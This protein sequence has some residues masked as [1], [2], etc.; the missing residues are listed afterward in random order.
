MS[1]AFE[2]V[3]NGKTVQVTGCSPN[4]TLLDFLRQKGFTGSKEGCAE[5]DCGACSVAILDRA[6]DGKAAYR[7][8][9]SCLVPACLLAGREVISVEGVASDTELHP[10]QSKMVQCHGSQCGYC[11]PGFV[12]SLFEGY[13]GKEGNDREEI[14]ELLCGNLCRCTGYRSIQQAAVEAFMGRDACNGHDPFRLALEKSLL[15][16]DGVDYQQGAER[17]F[18]PATLAEALTLRRDHPEARFIVGATELGL[19]ITKRYKKFE[20]LI[21]L[22]AIPELKQ[23]VRTETGWSIGAA[24][25]LTDIDDTLGAEMPEMRKML[26]VF[27]SRQIRNRAT[28]GGNIVTASPIGDSA[29]VLLAMDA[30]VVIASLKAGEGGVSGEVVQE[31]TVPIEEFFVAYRKTALQ[32]GEILKSI[33]LPS[34]RVAEGI[35]LSVD[36]CKVSRRREM[37]ISTVAG[38]FAAGIDAEGLIK[39]VRLAYGGVAAKPVRAKKTEAALLGKPW[40]EKTLTSALPIL[41]AEF[42]PIS[43]V[44]AEAAYRAG[45][46]TSL[47]EKFYHEHSTSKAG[48]TDG[49]PRVVAPAE[50]SSN[51]SRPHESARKH[52]TG[53]AK[54]VDDLPPERKM[55]EVW[56]VCAPHAKARI[57]TRD[58][59]TARA[60]PGIKAVL[61]AEDVP[62]LNDVGMK[63]DEPLFPRE[64]VLYHGQIVAL[65][66][67]ET[68][69]ACRAAAA[70][71]A[72]A[73][74][75]QQPILSLG[76][77]LEKKS[78]HNDPNFI[79]RGNAAEAIEQAPHTIA[80]TFEMGGQEHFYLETQAAWAEPAEDGAV[81]VSSST[82]HP[83]EIQAVI[84]HILHIAANKVVVQCPRMG[85][86]FGGKET[87]AALPAALAALAAHCTGQPVRVR[88]N[89]D[90]D[91]MITGHRHPFL[92]RYSVGFGLD[93]TLQGA[94]IDLFSDG[95]W[96]LDL[97]QAVTDRALFHLDN[98]YYIP[99]V[100]FS[101]RVAKTNLSSNTA[102]RGFGG[103]QGMLVIEEM[104]DRIARTLNLPPELVRERN[105][106]RGKGE[107]NTTHY[108]QEIEDNRIQT[109]WHELVA[110]SHLAER[111]KEIAEWNGQNPFRKR[112]IAIT[113][114][115]FGISF[116]VTHLNQAGALV[117]MYQDG[118]IQV[119]H[120]GTEM[121]QGLHTNMAAIAAQALGVYPDSVRVMHTSTDKV[122]NTSAT[123][124]SSGTDLNG[125]AVKNA[126]EILKARLAPIAAALLDKNS[127]LC[128]E[129][130]NLVFAD[131][132]VYA[133]ERPSD[134]LPITAVLKKA[135]MERVSLSANGFYCTPGIHWDRVA[136]RGKPFHYFAYGA[137]VSEV[138]VD[139]FTGM[140]HLRRVDILHDVGD[141]INEGINRGQVEG[142]FI[143]GMGWL[144]TEEL[145]WDK[146]GRLLTH[147]PDTYK[148]PAIGD[149]P[150]EFNVSLLRNA[151]QKT[152]VHGSKAVGEPPLMLAISVREAIRDAVAAFGSG[153]EQVP[154]ESPATAEAIFKAVREIRSVGA[155]TKSKVARSYE[156]AG[157]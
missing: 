41:A 151:A 141:S 88:F 44:R 56:P 124:A 25:T 17:F 128:I 5:G 70:K 14:N 140:H 139:G 75:K 134:S 30:K 154:L 135:Y 7:S 98:A 82:Q 102:F 147:S 117:L 65:V 104:L 39:H 2:F 85:G 33:L 100:E 105:L 67:G 27:G 61:M 53:E 107:T 119:N 146:E 81:F 73:Y 129:P 68:V 156:L 13:Y 110:T 153:A 29:P 71:V 148:I 94:K 38:C 42:T 16:L 149:A 19:E 34:M 79:R 115:K 145:K 80:G 83:S 92:A 84:S 126:C 111:R 95:G 122:P 113:P 18:R 54:Y 87:Q 93:G 20:T 63:G 150:E 60:M 6:A 138:E 47:F 1:S 64:Q 137:A 157:H 143:Q 12:I 97:S 52:V 108:G 48:G 50:K 131:G 24:A 36:W 62:G 51:N 116:T 125:M 32:P 123:A 9:N 21:S 144:T 43:D 130:S 15:P 90:Q 59:V 37:D 112:G 99:S 76:E 45:L 72:I 31:R 96:S 132:K 121:G 89:R 22:E 120:G 69:E 23:I 26:R 155:E 86:G 78:F 46:I 106:Y 118:T 77:A 55:L 57:L 8:I 103:P 58:A 127:A 152:V 66:V 4:L 91:M 114:V 40:E 133:P 136:G 142:G 109:I 35:A 10:V 3:L 11:T 101:G 28:M 49:E 74:G